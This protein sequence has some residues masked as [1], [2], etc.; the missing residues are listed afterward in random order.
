MFQPGRLPN[1]PG[2]AGHLNALLIPRALYAEEFQAVFTRHGKGIRPRPVFFSP[3]RSG[4]L[5]E[6]SCRYAAGPP[7]YPGGP[8]ED[9]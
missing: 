4:R 8:A 9:G 5:P 6:P 3:F 2:T 1:V 7:E